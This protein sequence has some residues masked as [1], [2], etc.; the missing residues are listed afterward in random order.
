MD[1]LRAL[2]ALFPEMLQGRYHQEDRVD[3]ALGWT[4]YA[5]IST[6][7]FP[8]MLGVKVAPISPMSFFR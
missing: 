1:Q 3:S 2:V 6:V 7:F 5:A 4:Y 8:D